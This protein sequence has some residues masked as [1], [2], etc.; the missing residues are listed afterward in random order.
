MS[1]VKIIS[2]SLN[3]I[4]TRFKNKQIDPILSENYDIILFQDTKAKYEQIDDKLK[5]VENY[6]SYFA[7]YEPSRTAG[8]AT[9]SLEKPK[10]AK[11]YFKLPDETLKGKVLN[12]VFDN[13]E[14]INILS[15]SASG[16]KKNLEAKI[17]FYEKLIDFLKE[18]ASENIIL[19]GDF[20]IA[21][22]DLDV[23]DNETASK[24]PFSL[25][26][27]RK[28]LNEIEKLGF[29]D[30]F[31]KLN[32]NK[33]EFTYWSSPKNKEEDNGLRL[34]YFSVSKNL[35]DS[36]VEANIKSDIEGSK[37]VPIELIIDI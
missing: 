33:Q 20:A 5:E 31:R 6:N 9:Y 22:K 2:W 21:H 14:I 32:K 15:P 28:V 16:G 18:K 19:C 24:S 10:L 8:V 12:L 4:R 7:P 30:S 11:K 3:G 36:I 34:D 29:V 37:H 17:E 13:F 26:E 25:E 1:K 23:K 27:E 35:S